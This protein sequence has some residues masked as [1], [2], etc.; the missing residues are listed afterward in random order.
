MPGLIGAVQPPTSLPAAVAPDL[1]PASHPVSETVAEPTAPEPRTK[2]DRQRKERDVSMAELARDIISISEQE[3]ISPESVDAA[4]DGE[5]SD[6]A[7]TQFDSDRQASFDLMIGPARKGGLLRRSKGQQHKDPV[8]DSKGF[9][10]MNELGTSP[11]SN[12]RRA[13]SVL[14][15]S[16]STE[17]P[18]SGSRHRLALGRPIKHALSPHREAG[19]SCWA[20]QEKKL[21]LSRSPARARFSGHLPDLNSPACSCPVWPLRLWARFSPDAARQLTTRS[22]RPSHTPTA[23]RQ[24]NTWASALATFPLSTRRVAQRAERLR[25]RVANIG[26]VQMRAP[27]SACRTASI[28]IEDARL[29]RSHRKDRVARDDRRFLERSCCCCTP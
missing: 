20:G 19:Q 9:D 6:A 11:G 13:R 15:G 24:H 18:S 14:A 12:P 5:E 17:A 25:R 23:S 21:R 28:V 4:A 16:G 7:T 8:D 1:G 29:H 22:R 2:K 26:R 10:P 3:P 27:E